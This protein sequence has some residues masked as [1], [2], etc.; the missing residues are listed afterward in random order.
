MTIK[1]TNKL[2]QKIRKTVITPAEAR[3]IREQIRRKERNTLRVLKLAAKTPITAELKSKIRNVRI[4]AKD[5]LKVLNESRR[6]EKA[7]K[8]LGKFAKV[9][10]RYL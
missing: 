8:A 7:R 1:V 5:F 10:L 3:H 2:L 4:T 6:D 9:Y